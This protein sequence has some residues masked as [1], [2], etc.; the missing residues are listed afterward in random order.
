[1]VW[2]CDW[3]LSCWFSLSSLSHSVLNRV[4][5]FYKF[6]YCF[7]HPSKLLIVFF[8]CIF[9]SFNYYSSYFSSFF[10]IILIRLWLSLISLAIFYSRLLITCCWEDTIFSCFAYE[11]LCCCWEV[12][13]FSCHSCCTL[14]NLWISTLYKI[15]FNNS[16]LAPK[17][18]FSFLT[19]LLV[20][21]MLNLVEEYASGV[22]YRFL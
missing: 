18:I 12:N 16:F 4:T 5:S 20:F 11:S 14:F 8:S 15:N 3:S 1:M 9:S 6:T 19:L 21:K 22:L 17:P 13:H 7:I 2:I 10:A